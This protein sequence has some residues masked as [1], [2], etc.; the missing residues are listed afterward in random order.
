MPRARVV[1]RRRY[2]KREQ[3]AECRSCVVRSLPNG[4]NEA[5]AVRRIAHGAEYVRRLY[6][7]SLTHGA[8]TLR[9]VVETMAPGAVMMGSDYPLNMGAADPVAH[10]RLAGLDAMVEAGVLGGNARR[11]LGT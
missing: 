9:L 7:D 8:A 3:L 10:V 2:S 1:R 4:S 11:F 6:A 5:E